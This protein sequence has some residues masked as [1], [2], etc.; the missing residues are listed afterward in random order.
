MAVSALSPEQRKLLLG[1]G[2]EAVRDVVLP[3]LRY[4][5]DHL[6]AVREGAGNELGVWRY[7]GGTD[8]Y[9]YLLHHYLT[10]DVCIAELHALGAVQVDRIQTELRQFAARQFGWP[11]DI[12]AAELYRRIQETHEEYLQ[13]AELLSKYERLVG[14]AGS[15]LSRFFN[16]LP[17]SQLAI[18]I[19][20]EAPPAY[21]E[22]APLDRSGPAHLVAS[23]SNAANATAY[24]DAV[25]M[26]H[27]TVPGHHLQ[28]ALA[29]DFNIPT[30]QKL[31]LGGVYV[32]HPPFQAFTE[33]W[34]LY[35]ERLAYEMGLYDDDPVGNLWRLRLELVRA[36][37]LVAD[38]GLN[39][40]GW[41]WADAAAYVE[42][43]LG[44]RQG[45]GAMLRFESAPAQAC[46]YN[47]GYFKILQLRQRAMDRLGPAFDIREFHEQVLRHGAIP[48][49]ILDRL[50]EEWL[51]A[52]LDCS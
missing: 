4:L 23:L 49:A 29:L 10:D 17:K 2:E 52:K 43:V 32:Q 44:Q 8:Y 37:R 22:N 20:P 31:P 18:R 28:F 9:R 33:G 45:I 48:L 15:S 51:A 24:D 13:G 11:I 36:V 7:A 50:I 12:G 1:Q 41:S 40:S 30:L 27:E 16:G 26:H 25:L 19:D 42:E 14:A 5:R 38:T 21:Y 34:A 6:V 39:G 47:Y 35:A 3:A 46:G